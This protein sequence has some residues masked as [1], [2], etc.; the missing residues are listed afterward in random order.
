MDNNKALP[1]VSATLLTGSLIFPG[2]QALASGSDR[3]FE[4]HCSRCHRTATQFKTPPNEIASL[5]KAGT[6]RQHR[7]TLDD[8]TI[9][10]I[11]DYLQEQ[12]S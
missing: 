2:S 1:Y 9:Q 6:I 5:L 10:T 11:V 4:Q 3:L 7:F 8:E 12:N